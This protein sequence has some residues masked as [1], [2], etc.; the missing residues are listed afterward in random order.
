MALLENES[1]MM[2]LG[3][4]SKR[5]EENLIGAI[6]LFKDILSKHKEL[7]VIVSDLSK[8]LFL[9]MCEDGLLNLEDAFIDLEQ[10]KNEYIKRRQTEENPIIEF[11]LSP[12]LYN[13][14][15]D[16]EVYY[17]DKFV[18]SLGLSFSNINE[19]TIPYNLLTLKVKGLNSFITDTMAFHVY[20]GNFNFELID[21]IR[22]ILGIYEIKD[23][24]V[25]IT[26]KEIYP[27]IKSL[28]LA[29]DIIKRHYEAM[30]KERRFSKVIYF[31][32][33]Y[34]K[35]EFFNS[36][37]G[38]RGKL[39]YLTSSFTRTAINISEFPTIQKEDLEELAKWGLLTLDTD[40]L[41]HFNHET[42]SILPFILDFDERLYNIYQKV[43]DICNFFKSWDDYNK[44]QRANLFK[45]Y[46]NYIDDLE[47]KEKIAFFT[48][49]FNYILSNYEVDLTRNSLLAFQ[50]YCD[51]LRCFKGLYEEKGQKL[52][53]EK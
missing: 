6:D 24:K 50:N 44:N 26:S 51:E 17:I 3:D 18:K 25:I 28:D 46:I 53:R 21:I 30:F 38:Q 22:Y 15:A 45:A 12:T 20:Y 48:E 39:D 49:K 13:Y 27:K 5:R 36:F 33:V 9:K 4:F 1:N 10:A 41:Y 34:D 14:F 47:T 35:D 29:F 32:D 43:Y 40:G 2:T 11:I 23:K 7:K 37:N 19:N 8:R 52:I 16:E 42:Y 31:Q